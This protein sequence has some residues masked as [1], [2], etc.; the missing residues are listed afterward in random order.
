MKRDYQQFLNSVETKGD[1]IFPTFIIWVCITMTGC[2]LAYLIYFLII[3]NVVHK[4]KS[5]FKRIHTLRF[6]HVFFRV[7]H[8]AYFPAIFLGVFAIQVQQDAVIILAIVV[9]LIWI[10]MGL[11]L[12]FFLLTRAEFGELTEWFDPNLRI[13]FGSF[14]A[15]YQKD[16]IRFQMFVFARKAWMGCSLGAMA[17]GYDASNSALFWAQ[18]IVTLAPLAIYVFILLWKRPYIDMIHLIIDAVINMLNAIT[19]ILSLLAIQSQPGTQQAIQWIVLI[20]QIPCAV[21]VVAAYFWSC[22]FYYGYTEV[23]QVFCCKGKPEQEESDKQLITMGG[24]GSSGSGT[25]KTQKFLVE[26][27][28]LD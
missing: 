27:D 24:G 6:V 20:V 18:M 1:M 23:S 19:L 10:G 5:A 25:Q 13:R 8:A 9:G 22:I 17:R 16:R 3:T 4:G 2:L 11:P 26:D 21:L 14:Y 28:D 7:L 15:S 12:F